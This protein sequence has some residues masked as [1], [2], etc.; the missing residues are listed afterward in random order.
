MDVI[1]VV[2]VAL[3]DGRAA[4]L[5]REMLIIR[6]RALAHSVLNRTK[7]VLQRLQA[8]I[9]DTADDAIDMAVEEHAA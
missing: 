9:N 8:A 5:Q 6:S 7:T 2:S 3:S 4:G 1:L